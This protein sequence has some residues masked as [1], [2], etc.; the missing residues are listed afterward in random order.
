MKTNEQTKCRKPGCS[1]EA[2]AWYRMGDDAHLITVCADHAR[3]LREAV[4]P[5]EIK[6]RGQMHNG[7]AEGSGR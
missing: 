2:V 4:E 3:E 7:I 6:A 5:W 1:A